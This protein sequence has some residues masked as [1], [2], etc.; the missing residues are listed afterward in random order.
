MNKFTLDLE[1][2]MTEHAAGWHVIENGQRLFSLEATQPDPPFYRFRVIDA[3]CSSE[4]I[5]EVLNSS[6]REPRA[7]LVYENRKYK[8]L[9]EDQYMF[10]GYND[11]DVSIKDYRNIYIPRWWHKLFF[12]KKY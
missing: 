10:G 12:W 11:G 8:N 5:S 6:K 4:Q 3:N 7:S 9:V 2:K 1:R